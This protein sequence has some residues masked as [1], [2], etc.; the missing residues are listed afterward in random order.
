MNKSDKLRAALRADGNK[1]QRADAVNIVGSSG[2]LSNMLRSGEL[3]AQDIDG[4]AHV[5]LDPNHKK[6]RKTEKSL[7]IKRRA[8]K[9]RGHKKARKPARKTMRDIANSVAAAR[10]A[11]QA[12]ITGLAIDNMIEAGIALA[13]VVRAQVDGLEDNPALTAAVEQQER[14]AKLARAVNPPCPF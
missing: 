13:A 5:V 6:A 7:P 12:L 4:V 8:T 3:T 14:A 1:M 9:K 2:G 10:A 11:D